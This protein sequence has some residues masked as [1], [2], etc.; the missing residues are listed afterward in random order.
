MQVRKKNG[1]AF[2][3][4]L[5]IFIFVNLIMMYERIINFDRKKC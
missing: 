2:F 5:K 4:E 1:D 3:T